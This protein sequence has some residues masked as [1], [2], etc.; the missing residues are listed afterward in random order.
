MPLADQQLELLLAHPR[1]SGL[2]LPVRR[3]A[4]V[5][6]GPTPDLLLADLE[7]EWRDQL[8][9]RLMGGSTPVLFTSR[10][11]LPLQS[12][13]GHLSR[14]LAGLW[15]AWRQRWRRILAT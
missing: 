2:E 4:R 14:Q 9:D 12:G 7:Q 6:E 1:C 8:T 3:I 5:L 11:E 10:G 15:A 13:R